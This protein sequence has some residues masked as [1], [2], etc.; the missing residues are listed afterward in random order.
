MVCLW[1]VVPGQ[2]GGFLSYVE[3]I[4]VLPSILW[5]GPVDCLRLCVFWDPPISPATP[6]L[7]PGASA[8]RE[9]L[10]PPGGACHRPLRTLNPDRELHRRR[11]PGLSAVAG[12]DCTVMDVALSS[13]VLLA[14]GAFC[15]FSDWYCS[16]PP[17]V[18]TIIL[19]CD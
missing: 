11:R 5:L 17:E 16:S 6:A 12:A 3:P 13:L 15:A 9:Q 19:V 8:A 10:K 2:D 14:S 4:R 18:T 7:L 1:A